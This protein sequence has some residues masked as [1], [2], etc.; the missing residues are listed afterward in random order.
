[1]G[2]R[3]TADRIMRDAAGTNRYDDLRTARALVRSD[4]AFIYWYRKC[5]SNKDV[6]KR[7]YQLQVLWKRLGLARVAAVTLRA[8]K[9]AL[10]AIVQAAGRLTSGIAERAI[11][12]L[13]TVCKKVRKTCAANQ[14]YM[15]L[16]LPFVA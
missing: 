8:L 4:S 10:L 5:D 6:L 12:M 16:E 11:E 13:R 3:E 2:V 14:Q 15:Q 7:A 1:M 9:A